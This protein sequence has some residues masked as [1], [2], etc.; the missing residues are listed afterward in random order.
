VEFRVRNRGLDTQTLGRLDQDVGA[1]E[2]FA[3]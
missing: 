3:G 1:T 2:R